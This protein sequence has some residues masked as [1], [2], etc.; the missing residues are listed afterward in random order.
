MAGGYVREY[1]DILL[2]FLLK[3]VRPEKYRERVEMRGVLANVDL[4]KLPDA[5]IARI[6]AG[7]NLNAVLAGAVADGLNPQT[8]LRQPGLL[9]AAENDD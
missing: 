1:S 7:E 9:P 2:I 8:F 4:T 6:A 5:L 3:A